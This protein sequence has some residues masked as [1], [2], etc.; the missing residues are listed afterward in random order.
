MIVSGCQPNSQGDSGQVDRPAAPAVPEWRDQLQLSVSAELRA[1]TCSADGRIL[2]VSSGQQLWLV[3]NK[4]GQL[5]ETALA[6]A[7]QPIL[8]SALSADG[9]W[10]A[11][12]SNDSLQVHSV[13]DG[14]LRSSVRWLQ[15]VESVS[16]QIS[17]DGTSIACLRNGYLHLYH[18]PNLSLR[19]SSELPAS[20]IP[21][22]LLMSTNGLTL[23]VCGSEAI[24]F[25]PDAATPLW[26]SRLP[27]SF[28]SASL[29]ADGVYLAVEL[30]TPTEG[31]QLLLFERWSA[32]STWE[33]RHQGKP[34][35]LQFSPDGT[36]LVLSADRFYLFNCGM[37]RPVLQLRQPGP[38]SLTNG[39]VL[40]INDQA[41]YR[42]HTQD[43]NLAS[44]QLP[45]QLIGELM[46]VY[47]EQEWLFALNNHG[48]V[49]LIRL[50]IE[51]GKS[52]V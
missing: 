47:S 14:S 49:Y 25:A 23:A 30:E 32:E 15:P 28:Q 21:R 3:Q 11:L 48:L 37:A 24:V 17:Q 4:A 8:A 2:L 40:L 1:A 33:F 16:L 9:A 22:S 29:S 19:W 20:E 41:L 38:A 10:L 39:Q 27:G 52:G 31:N 42:F 12:A 35:C 36:W 5:S 13:V 26:R 18:G 51:T 34:T 6:L 50:P 43:Q 46:Y 45:R 7:E 44:F